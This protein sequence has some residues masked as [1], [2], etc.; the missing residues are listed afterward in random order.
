MGILQQNLDNYPE[1]TVL[2]AGEYELRVLKVELKDSSTG[3]PGMQVLFESIA[4]PEALPIS[5]WFTIPQGNITDKADI[6]SADGLRKFFQAL[7]G[8]H[9]PSNCDTDA[10]VGETIWATLKIEDS[11][12]FGQQNRISRFTRKA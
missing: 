3:K 12:D 7:S 8:G 11:T 9:D 6:L 5:K 4:H 10:L 2:P 1:P